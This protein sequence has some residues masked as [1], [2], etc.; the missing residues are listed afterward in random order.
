MKYRTL[1]KIGSGGT[2]TVFA[3]C[4]VGSSD[5]VALKRPHP[6]LFDDPRSLAALRREAQIASKL[7]HENVI[8]MHDLVVENENV[9]LVL[10]LVEGVSLAELSRGWDAVG[11]RDVAIAVRIA[12]DVCH[13]LEALHALADDHGEP[14]RL[15]HRDVSPDNVIVASN[16]IAKLTD[17]GLARSLDG[18]DRTTTDGV[19]KGKAGYL[20]PEYVR[21]APIDQR[22]DVFAVGVVLWETIAGRRLFRGENEADTLQRVLKCEVPKLGPQIGAGGDELDA[23]LAEA[24]ARGPADR[25]ASAADLRMALES[26]LAK[27]HATT[28]RASVR[29]SFPASVIA[30]LDARRDAMASALKAPPTTSRRRGLVVAGASALVAGSLILLIFK[31]DSHHAEPAALPPAPEIE[32]VDVPTPSASASAVSTP[33]AST[34]ASA[35]PSSSSRSPHV[36]R[37]KPPRASASG[38]ITPEPR[39]NPY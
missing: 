14:L 25:T 38:A 18:G 26:W 31:R 20:A 30:T 3:A 19:L 23:I 34:T 9:E 4:A 32:L 27:H 7:R 35:D 2:A 6:H 17:F 8:T 36:S 11:T 16:G 1:V 5:L 28:D 29:A 33:I 24:L 39:A 13:G 12:I 15:V 10:E 22:V 37:S 21:G